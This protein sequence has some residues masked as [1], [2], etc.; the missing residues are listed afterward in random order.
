[1]DEADVE[2]L[3]FDEAIFLVM[4]GQIVFEGVVGPGEFQKR[5]SYLI[6]VLLKKL[7]E[8]IFTCLDRYH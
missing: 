5:F 1:M 8:S 7:M 6:F 3:H 4:L 2:M